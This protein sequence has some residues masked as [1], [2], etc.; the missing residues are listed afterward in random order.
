MQVER[1]ASA[2]QLE[3]SHGCIYRAMHYRNKPFKDTDGS[4]RFM[5]SLFS[6]WIW[7]G[8]LPTMGYA[9]SRIQWITRKKKRDEFGEKLLR[10]Y[11]TLCKGAESIICYDTPWQLDLGNGSV[12]G[13]WDAIF[14]WGGK[15]IILKCNRSALSNESYFETSLDVGLSIAAAINA[16]MICNTLWIV[17]SGEFDTY[18][19]SI[20][21]GHCATVA[22]SGLLDTMYS[23]HP[24]SGVLCYQCE[25]NVNGTCEGKLWR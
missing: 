19:P 5:M 22:A 2:R 3:Y 6:E 15:S 13:T 18:T 8:R 20:V 1:C 16:N 23:G 11:T 12:T 9:T 24:F 4:C 25:L 10:M 21:G 17:G 7:S 14:I